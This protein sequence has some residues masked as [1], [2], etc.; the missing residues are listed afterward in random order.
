[1]L[2]LQGAIALNLR[3]GCAAGLYKRRALRIM[4]A[5]WGSG[6]AG[7]QILSD[8]SLP[9]P[10]RPE[11]ARFNH[12]FSHTEVLM[13]T[14]RRF[15]SLTAAFSISAAVGSALPP[16]AVA[17]EPVQAVPDVENAKFQFLGRLNAGNVYVRSGPG[18]N[19]YPTLK[20]DRDAQVKVVGIR[21]DWLKIV[22]PEN[23]FS[24]VSKALV[25]RQEGTNVGRITGE[26]V[27][28]RAGS[29]LNPLKVTVQCKLQKDQTVTI[30]DE[31]DEYYRIKP[32]ADAYVY[33][34]QRFVDP[35]KPLEEGAVVASNANATSAE[36]G[37]GGVLEVTQ[38]PVVKPAAPTTQAVARVNAEAE[39][40]RLEKRW[41][42]M[43]GKPIDVAPAGELLAD[44]EKLAAVE[45]LPLTMRR[46]IDIRM[47]VLRLKNKAR[48]EYLAFVQQ[49][50]EATEKLAAMRAEREKVEQRLSSGV[51]IYTA[52]GQF[53]ASSVKKDG[54]TLFRVIDPA[55]TRTLCY[56]QSDDPRAVTFTGKFV[57]VRGDFA[58][59]EAG[60]ALKI[61]EATDIAAVDPQRVNRGISAQI[62]PPSLIKTPDQQA[63]TNG[64]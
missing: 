5:E 54:Q 16:I 27:N 46:T 49:Q 9:A 23:S 21:F 6:R 14:T 41:K 39:F 63:S 36:T 4:S 48:Q 60:S 19:Y 35:V 1:M 24:F 25:E 12:G 20:L 18:D 55:T 43:D 32:P 40:D 15:L 47:Q 34:H 62:S 7:I 56:V 38:T 31:Q 11:V 51:A 33:V 26:N 3:F 59:A 44:Y 42:D 28:I 22:P 58:A 61:V 50:T 13:A 10:P 53:E 64:N 29:D 37:T 30:I 8:V 45:Q 52:V 2:G 57:G 17:N